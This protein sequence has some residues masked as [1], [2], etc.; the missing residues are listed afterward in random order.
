MQGGRWAG[1]G[2]GGGRPQVSRLEDFEA[3][4]E[5]EWTKPQGNTNWSSIGGLT[6]KG[7]LGYRDGLQTHND[8]SSMMVLN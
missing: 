8:A 7:G 5:A 4:A 3:M 2:A 1:A 6:N